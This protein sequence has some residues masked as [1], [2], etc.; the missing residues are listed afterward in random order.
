LPRVNPRRPGLIP[1]FGERYGQWA[2]RL[3]QAGVLTNPSLEEPMQLKGIVQ[4]VLDQCTDLR[5]RQAR[6]LGELL[7]GTMPCRRV[8]QTDIALGTCTRTVVKRSTKRAYRSV[9]N[10][11]VEAVDARRAPVGLAIR[12]AAGRLLVA[13]DRVDIGPHEVLKAAVPGRGCAAAVLFAAHRKWQV[14]KSQS[15]SEQGLLRLLATMVPAGVHVVV[16]ADRGFHRAELARTLQQLGLSYVIRISTRVTC[17][18]PF[19]SGRLGDL[20][21]ARGTHKDLGFA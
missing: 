10:C 17:S 4:W 5:R 19:Y 7:C 13:L 15:A 6:T 18:S 16:L 20:P 9:A 1:G 21:V 8:S 14:H 2:P 12:A 3:V 11:R